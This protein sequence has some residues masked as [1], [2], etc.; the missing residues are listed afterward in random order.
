MGKREG[1]GGRGWTWPRA[2]LAASV[3]LFLAAYALGLLPEPPD[4][5]EAVEDSAD[6]LGLWLYPFVAGA[7]FL[8]SFPPPF[9]AVWPGE[10]A[11]I[12]SGAVAAQDG[13]VEIVPL[14][15]IVWVVSAVAD[16]AAFA[17]GRRYGRGLLERHGPRFRATP[18]RIERLDAWFDR[19]G[20][21]VVAIGRLL[22]VARPLGPFV[23]GTSKLSYHR[24]LRW[25]LLG[26][27]LFSVGFSLL[28]YVFYRSYDELVVA[29]GRVGLAVV[30]TALVA[31]LLVVAV[32]RRRSTGA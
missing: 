6:S 11:V 9:C 5:R 25:N 18:E 7:A 32:R 23:A 17:V 2:A 19:W 10:F 4:G 13:K 16:S 26:V 27:T 29:I 21:A 22:P 20:A 1:G 24:F 28:G 14:I 30:G 31:G 12:F 15:A 8:E 3:V